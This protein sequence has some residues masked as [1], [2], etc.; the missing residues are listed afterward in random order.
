MRKTFN[1]GVGYV[2]VVEGKSASSAVTLLNKYGYPAYLIG[3]I[4][5]GGRERIR[6]V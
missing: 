3:T 5:K 2:I 1:M 4:E 6:Y